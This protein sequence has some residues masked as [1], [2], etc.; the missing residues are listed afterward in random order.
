MIDL[1]VLQSVSYVA[2]AIG[3]CIAAVYYVMT[4]RVQQANMKHTLE[5]RQA[6]ILMSL[7]QKWSEPEFQ[8][9]WYEVLTWEWRD[10]DDYFEKYGRRSN[11]DAWRKLNIIGAFFE[12]M[13]VFVK[14]GFINATLVDDLMSMY[15][16]M[17]WQKM[18][19]LAKEMRMKMNSPT[20]AEFA[21]YLYDVIY[22][23]WKKQHPETPEPS[24]PTI[25]T[26][27]PPNKASAGA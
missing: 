24:R 18:G 16:V 6:Q 19:S 9:A 23:I 15:I 11:P 17:Y 26:S 14:R 5:T 27:I 3:V 7:Y 10:Y 20:T 25:A 8:D 12:G 1:V 21:E 22:E 13:G 2:A 4:L